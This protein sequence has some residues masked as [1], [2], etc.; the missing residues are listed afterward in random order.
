MG[1]TIN[2]GIVGTTRPSSLKLELQKIYEFSGKWKIGDVGRTEP[3]VCSN[4]WVLIWCW[5][6][7]SML[8]GIIS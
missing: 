3:N 5:Q 8:Q 1:N 2:R 4:D 7:R 6:I